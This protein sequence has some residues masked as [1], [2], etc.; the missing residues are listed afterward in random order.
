MA[1]QNV[2]LAIER[3]VGSMVDFDAQNKF[4]SL[5]N[6]LDFL[7][8][9]GHG[10]EFEEDIISLLFEEPG[11]TPLA[12]K[13]IKV[14]SMDALISKIYAHD[15]APLKHLKN[16]T[17]YLKSTPKEVL[18]V[19]FLNEQPIEYGDGEGL[20]RHLECARLKAF[21][22]RVRDIY[23]PKLANTNKPSENH[24]I[25]TSDNQQQA[26]EILEW[27]DLDDALGST[28]KFPFFKSPR[29]LG[30][31]S[32]CKI[33]E[34]SLNTVTCKVLRGSR[35]KYH[36]EEVGI[37]SS[38]Q[39]RMLNEM[40]PAIYSNYITNFRG[41][42][43]TAPYH[44]SRFSSLAAKFDSEMYKNMCEPIIV[45]RTNDQRYVILDGLHRASLLLRS[46][47]RLIKGV[48]V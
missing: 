43:L 15:Y 22:R 8:I 10:L 3:R 7:L 28:P 1:L 24:V 38:P 2:K 20:F 26:L 32:S 21:K 25:H 37:E 39:F 4:Y 33:V 18:F 23:N 27:L 46:G 6:R 17:K 41:T 5:K 9:W 42:G 16:K 48:V 35:W 44:L 31:I 34:M 36:T 45:K 47:E 13:R 40:N 14:K 29:Y 19:F 12:V 30:V 11:F